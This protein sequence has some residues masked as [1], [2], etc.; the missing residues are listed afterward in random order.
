[1][2]RK[3][4]KLT[5]EDNTDKAGGI[6][7]DDISEDGAS[8]LRLSETEKEDYWKIIEQWYM[9]CRSRWQLYTTV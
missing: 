1:M 6:L 2:G 3:K 7:K 5:N 9:Y 4:K 8:Y